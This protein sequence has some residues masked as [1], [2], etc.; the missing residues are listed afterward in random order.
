MREM[1]WTLVGAGA[2]LLLET[3]L[4]WGLGFGKPPIGLTVLLSLILAASA[5]LQLH[6]IHRSRPGAQQNISLAIFGWIT[7]FAW[8]GVVVAVVV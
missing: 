3:G 6:T 7:M 8:W 4:V 2:A 1:G 5:L